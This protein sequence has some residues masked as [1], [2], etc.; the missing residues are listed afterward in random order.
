MMRKQAVHNWLI[1]LSTTLFLYSCGIAR[2]GMVATSTPDAGGP[3]RGARAGAA[4]Q[5]GMASWYGPGFHGKKTANGEV[6]D[7]DDLTAAH[8]TLPFNTRVRV[9]NK[10]NGKQVDVRI[11]DR[12]PYVGDRIIDL[13]RSAAR[14]IDMIGPGVAEVELFLLTEGDRPVSGRATN[15]E[16]FTVQIAS[17]DSYDKAQQEA[18]KIRGAEVIRVTVNGRDFYRVYYG[19]YPTMADAGKGM[20]EVNRMGLTGF[21]KQREN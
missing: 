8:R 9:L 18:R 21:I 2:T 3:A 6:Y 19:S 1:L 12:G 15:Q 13:S 16:S 10:M 7:M 14:A 20:N 17:F 4:I 11:N 5:S